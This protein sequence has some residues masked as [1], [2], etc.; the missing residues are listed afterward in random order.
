MKRRELTLE[1]PMLLLEQVERLQVPIQILIGVLIIPIVA[2]VVDLLVRPSVGQVHLATVG[3]DVGKG[4]EDMRERFSLMRRA[5][6]EREIEERGSATGDE[7][8]FDP[9]MA[10]NFVHRFPL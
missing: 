5:M 9:R 1:I 6:S 10:C 4:V 7:R 3:L 8:E 2:R